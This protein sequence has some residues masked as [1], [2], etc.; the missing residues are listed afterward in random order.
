MFKRINWRIFAILFVMGLLGVL[1]VL[2]FTH[3]LIESGAFGEAKTQEMSFPLVIA[4]ALGQNGVLLAVVILVGM[5]LSERVGLQMP[6][7][8]AW[9]N[10]E[11]PPNVNRIVVPGL[12]VGAAAGVILVAIEALFF[13]AASTQGTVSIF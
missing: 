8:R 1:S 4:L 13:C 6:L 3:D 5:S 7:I 12:L 9:T 11:R 10:R 2:P